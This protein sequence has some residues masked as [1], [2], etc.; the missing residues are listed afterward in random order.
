ML[1]GGCTTSL[2]PTVIFD[3]NLQTDAGRI[4]PGNTGTY[5]LVVNGDIGDNGTT[6][7]SFNA[8]FR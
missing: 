5:T 8:Q 1:T 3:T 2:V 7:Y 4:T 6:N